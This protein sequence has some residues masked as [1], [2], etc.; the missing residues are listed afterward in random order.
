MTYTAVPNSQIWIDGVE[1][2][3]VVSGDVTAAEAKAREAIDGGGAWFVFPY[4][5]GHYTIW[6]SPSSSVI[7]LYVG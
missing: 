2:V 1:L 4:A 5:G 3:N 6:L 7:A